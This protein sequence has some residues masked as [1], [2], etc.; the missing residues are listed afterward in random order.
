MDELHRQ[1]V[2]NRLI[3]AVTDSDITR[4]LEVAEEA[5]EFQGYGGSY[6]D[7][8]VTALVEACVSVQTHPEALPDAR[9]IARSLVAWSSLS[10]EERYEVDWVLINKWCDLFDERCFGPMLDAGVLTVD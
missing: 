10:G 3:D 7:N 6:Y 9:L 1:D 2:V 4:I 5:R 8:A